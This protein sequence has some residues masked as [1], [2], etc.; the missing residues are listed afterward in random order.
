GFIEGLKKAQELNEDKL[1]SLEDIK[2]A[3]NLAREFT[4]IFHTD[5]GIT[6]KNKYSKEEIIQQLQQVKQPKEFVQ[7]FIDINN[8]D[9]DD[10]SGRLPIR[11][12][13]IINNIIQGI[14]VF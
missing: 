6:T 4:D 9:D 10:E 8:Y 13:K 1:F 2:K 11:R 12:L 7:E 3:I 14:W 5:E